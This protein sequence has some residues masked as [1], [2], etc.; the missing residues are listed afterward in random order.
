MI[1]WEFQLLLKKE[2][3]SLTLTVVRKHLEIR[4]RFDA[5]AEP[6]MQHKIDL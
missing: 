4:A 6:K 3:W 1:R 2:K 5:S